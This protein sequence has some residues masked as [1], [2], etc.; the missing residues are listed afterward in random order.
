MQNSTAT[1]FTTPFE[2]DF[3]ETWIVV[4]QMFHEA[5]IYPVFIIVAL[6]AN[7]LIT[8][9][10]LRPVAV[11]RCGLMIR[12]YYL[13]IALSDICYLISSDLMVNFAVCDY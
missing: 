13:L 3:I 11:K 5:F 8:G 4:V 2:S 6:L 12:I 1:P 9:V 7:L 10:F